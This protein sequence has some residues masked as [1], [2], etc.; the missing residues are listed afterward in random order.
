MPEDIPPV[1]FR[2]SMKPRFYARLQAQADA[3]G[4]GNA[5]LAR[6]AISEY[7]KRNGPPADPPP[8]AH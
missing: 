5:E 1:S 6:K 3:E 4:I 2:V 7:L 8:A